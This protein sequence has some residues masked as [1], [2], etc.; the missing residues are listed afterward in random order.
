MEVRSPTNSRA[1]LSNS[2]SDL[3]D[4]DQISNQMKDFGGRN[5]TRL[6]PHP[7]YGL[8]LDE[9]LARMIKQKKASDM[10]LL[11]KHQ[12][13]NQ[14]YYSQGPGSHLRDSKSCS[15]QESGKI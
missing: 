3:N 15:L 10:Q 12:D 5:S 13:K 4:G 11:S 9:N 14:L 7:E 1:G 6:A 2:I 8:G